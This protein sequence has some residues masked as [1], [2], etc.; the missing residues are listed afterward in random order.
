[1][2]AVWRMRDAASNTREEFSGRTCYSNTS[3]LCGEKVVNVSLSSASDFHWLDRGR[4]CG[5]RK[6]SFALREHF[7]R[8][9]SP[10][11]CYLISFCTVVSMIAV[12]KTIQLAGRDEREAVPIDHSSVVRRWECLIRLCRRKPVVQDEKKLR[13]DFMRPIRGHSP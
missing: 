10:I 11:R 1:M 5:P 2:R 6:N 12:G 3:I 7:C 8:Q 4:L 13:V 9:N